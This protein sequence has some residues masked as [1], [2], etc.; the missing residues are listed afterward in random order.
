HIRAGAPCFR[1][2][3]G[4]GHD[5]QGAVECG[6]IEADLRLAVWAG[7]DNS[8]KARERLL[9]WPLSAE[10]RC[11]VAARANG[12]PRSLHAVDEL[13]IQV[14]DFRAELALTVEVGARIG[15]LVT[16][17]VENAR[18][19]RPYRHPRLFS[20][21]KPLDLERDRQLAARPRLRGHR[22]P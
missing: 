11:G 1:L 20:C 14:A 2:R 10:L 7:L 6:D 8:R 22:K 9:C 18:I 19:D 15:R 3:P 4:N 13:P 16:V 21:T 12:A 5:P 17:Q